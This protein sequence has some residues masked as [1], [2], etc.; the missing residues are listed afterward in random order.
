MT[1]S[2][3][4]INIKSNTKIRHVIFKIVLSLLRN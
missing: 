1:L 4:Q 3:I 2:K